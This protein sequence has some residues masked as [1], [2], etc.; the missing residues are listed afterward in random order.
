MTITKRITERI[1]VTVTVIIL[2]TTKYNYEKKTRLPRMRLRN[3]FYTDNLSKYGYRYGYGYE[4]LDLFFHSV[5]K[6]KKSQTRTI[7]KQFRKSF[8][9]FRKK[10]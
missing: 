2:K 8:F 9:Q 5:N 6:V 4:Y 7:L 1:M 3:R 10:N